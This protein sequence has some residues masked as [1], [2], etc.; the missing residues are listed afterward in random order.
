MNNDSERERYVLELK[1]K[2]ADYDFQT[3]IQSINNELKLNMFRAEKEYE[4]KK[5]RIKLSKQKRRSKS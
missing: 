2:Y 1:K 3:K 4:L 5:N